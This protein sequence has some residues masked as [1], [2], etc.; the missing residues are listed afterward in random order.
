MN[1]EEKILQLVKEENPDNPLTYVENIVKDLCIEKVNNY[2]L[3][4]NKCDKICNCNKTITYG[5]SNACVLIIGE[6]GSLNQQ[7][8]DFNF[9]SDDLPFDDLNNQMP[10]ANEAGDILFKVLDQ[11]NINK[12]ELF[13]INSINCFPYR[14]GKD[15]EKIKRAPTVTERNNCKLYLDYVLKVVQPLLIICLGSVATNDINE[16]I[17]KHNISE[18]RG[19]YFNYRGI[20]VM[21]TFNPQYFIELSK[22]NK[23]DEDTINTLKWNFYYDIQKAFIDLQKEYPDI[24]IINNYEE[25]DE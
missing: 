15:N 10:F 23:I 18:I 3:N 22:L 4:C 6:S 8:K 9:P 12:E 1:N 24:N 25:E 21:P 11:L 17:G 7:D 20:K 5:N 14:L 13:F 2:I 16:E 19:E